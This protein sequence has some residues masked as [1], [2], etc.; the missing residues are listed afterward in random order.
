MVTDKKGKIFEDR[1]K[2]DDRR[3]DIQ[4]VEK[5]KRKCQRRASKK[6]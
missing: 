3:K 5:E 1:R 2:Q 4:P 6:K